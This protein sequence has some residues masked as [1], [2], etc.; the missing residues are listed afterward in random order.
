MT[1]YERLKINELINYFEVT[2]DS[3][4]D[5]LDIF[6]RVNS[7]GTIL[8]KTD[9]LFSTIVAYWQ[10]ARDEIDDFLFNGINSLGIRLEKN[11]S[12][13]SVKDIVED[14]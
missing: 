11:E 5:V 3:M 1:L 14:C 8:S 7:G 6:V 9:L 4:D 13:L 12:Y 10:S 2:G